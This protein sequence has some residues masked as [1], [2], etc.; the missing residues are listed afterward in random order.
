MRTRVPSLTPLSE[1]R[2]WC[3]CGCGVGPRRGSD[4]KLLWLWRRLAA[5]APTPPLAWEL[6]CAAGMAL[7]RKEKEKRYYPV[8]P[9]SLVFGSPLPTIVHT[10]LFSV[11]PLPPENQHSSFLR[12]GAGGLAG[13]GLEKRR[14]PRAG[15]GAAPQ[16]LKSPSY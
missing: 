3:C 5:A 10:G 14:A 11:V 1:L 13:R 8:F 2:I 4:P 12:P 6:Q 9:F 7:K 16:M 15:R